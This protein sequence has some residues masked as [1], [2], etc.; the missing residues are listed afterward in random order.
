MALLETAVMIWS[1]DAPTVNRIAAYTGDWNATYAIR[2]AMDFM[3]PESDTLVPWRN[4]QSRN[5][6]YGQAIAILT[7]IDSNLDASDCSNVIPDTKISI[8]MPVMKQNTTIA[9]VSAAAL[10]RQKGPL[11]FNVKFL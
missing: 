6:P 7:G 11:G 4:A 5:T 9:N 8:N 1:V 2:S 10:R 3:K